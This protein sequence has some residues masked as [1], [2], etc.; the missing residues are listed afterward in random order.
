LQSGY[1]AHKNGFCILR[2]TEIWQL[3]RRKS[4]N[5]GW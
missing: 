2:V 4:L 3:R 1:T 5:F